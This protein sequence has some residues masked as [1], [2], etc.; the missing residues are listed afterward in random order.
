MIFAKV[1]H[2]RYSQTEWVISDVMK[3]PGRCL[4][5]LHTFNWVLRVSFLIVLQFYYY[6][7]DL[8]SMIWSRSNSLLQEIQ[9]TSISPANGQFRTEE[10]ASFSSVFPLSW[11]WVWF[12]EQMDM[13]LENFFWCSEFTALQLFRIIK[14][15]ANPL[16]LCRLSSF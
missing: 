8:F 14:N 6:W 10:F 9:K 11:E 1:A 3:L 2:F 5:C 12:A 15:M 4:R 16:L 13:A 7:T